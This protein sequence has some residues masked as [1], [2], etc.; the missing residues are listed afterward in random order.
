M[1]DECDICKKSED[2]VS[3]NMCWA[4]GEYYCEDCGQFE[5]VHDDYIC[6]ECFNYRE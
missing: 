5:I 3:I 2:I 1:G 4:C 6:Y